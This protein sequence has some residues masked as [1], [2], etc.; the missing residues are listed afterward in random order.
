MFLAVVEHAAGLGSRPRAA[1]RRPPHPGGRTVSRLIGVYRANGGPLGEIAYVLGKLVGRAHC[2]L[3]DVTHSP[4]RRKAEWDRMTAGLGVPF[5]LVHLNECTGE[6]QRLVP[7]K[8][9]APAV[10]AEVDGHLEVILTAAELEP[11]SGS[12]VTFERALQHALDRH[13]LDLGP[14]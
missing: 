9:V 12:V 8:D 4:V 1:A 6:L 7:S 2:A 5:E 13:S 10:V 3:C 14:A 11:L